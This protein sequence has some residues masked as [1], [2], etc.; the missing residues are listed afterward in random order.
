MMPLWM[1]VFGQHF[2]RGYDANMRI[3]IPYW[4]IISSLL[5]LV[6]PLLIGILIS[7]WK[8]AVKDK[9]RKVGYGLLLRTRQLI[10]F[11]VFTSAKYHKNSML[12]LF[13]QS[14]PF[15]FLSFLYRMCFEYVF[16]AGRDIRGGS[17]ECD[18]K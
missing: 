6:I 11:D 13:E 15:A 9:A 8:P 2:L 14:A 1:W 7:R 18:H 3:K 12:F 10:V 4:K 5:T 17:I 16:L